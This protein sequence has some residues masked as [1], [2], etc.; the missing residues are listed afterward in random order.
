MPG[1][2]NIGVHVE[3]ID[4]GDLS[5]FNMLSLSEPDESYEDDLDEM[6][7]EDDDVVEVDDSVC[8][9]D[10]ADLIFW[11]SKADSGL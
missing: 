11:V 1:V 9:I 2:R 6:F 7:A 4:I 5:A 10:S 8:I 3:I